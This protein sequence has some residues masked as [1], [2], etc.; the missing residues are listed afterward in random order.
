ML[1]PTTCAFATHAAST[2]AATQ[3]ASASMEVRTAPGLRP[4]P[5]RSTAS[6]PK[7]WWAR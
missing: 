5:G 7:P 2:N 1:W 4:W 6:T 3:S